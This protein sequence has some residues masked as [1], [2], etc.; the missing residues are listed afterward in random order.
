MMHALNLKEEP[1]LLR[2]YWKSLGTL[3]GYIEIK[4]KRIQEMS[5][6]GSETYTDILATASLV[7]LWLSRWAIDKYMQ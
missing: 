1:K 3:K 7:S 2:Y 4:C 6:G 5:S